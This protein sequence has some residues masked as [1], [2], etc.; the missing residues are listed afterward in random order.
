MSFGLENNAMI[1]THLLRRIAN[2]SFHA[3][4]NI[5]ERRISGSTKYFEA[6]KHRKQF[7]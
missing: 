3:P 5:D 2:A 1:L 7:N 6:I 4:K